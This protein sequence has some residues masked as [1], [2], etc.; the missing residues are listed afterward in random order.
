[1]TQTG[2][3]YPTM[4]DRKL[5]QISTNVCP[6]GNYELCLKPKGLGGTS[7]PPR[8][9]CSRTDD[10]RLTSPSLAPSLYTAVVSPPYEGSTVSRIGYP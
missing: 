4:L 2:I 7:Y 5:K 6:P 10:P 3:R 9:A 8:G 1:M